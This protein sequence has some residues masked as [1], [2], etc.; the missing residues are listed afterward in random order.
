MS[1]P[2]ARAA[3]TAAFCAACKFTNQLDAS[4]K[5]SGRGF[6]G[7]LEN[8]RNRSGVSAERRKFQER[9]SPA[10]CRKPLRLF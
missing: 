2:A 4:R 7:L 6:L 1:L 8:F 9:K 10:F 5:A 3:W